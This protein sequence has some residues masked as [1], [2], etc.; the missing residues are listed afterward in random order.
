MEGNSGAGTGRGGPSLVAVVTPGASV[1]VG[2]WV[3]VG[4][5]SVIAFAEFS[6]RLSAV[7]GEVARAARAVLISSALRH[8][9]APAARQGGP[10]RRQDLFRTSDFTRT[11]SA[12]QPGAAFLR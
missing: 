7:L 5:G 4:A 11:A 3:E 2:G 8:A 12:P 10:R 1:P 9:Q 6:E